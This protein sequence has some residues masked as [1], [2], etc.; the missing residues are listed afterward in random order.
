MNLLLSILPQIAQKA[1]VK[2]SAKTVK[3]NQASGLI[4]DKPDLYFYHHH[5]EHE[6]AVE[7]SA[8]DS[9]NRPMSKHSQ[10][11]KLNQRHSCLTS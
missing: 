8:L 9:T 5:H 11:M 3:L 1:H 4:M 10:T 7:Y 2:T 6:I